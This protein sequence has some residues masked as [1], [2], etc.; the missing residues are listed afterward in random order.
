MLPQ[1]KKLKQS[2]RNL[3]KNMTNAER[4][5][6]P[7]IRRKQLKGVQFYRQKVIVNYIVDFYCH[8]AKLVIEVDGGQHF[9]KQGINT[10]LKRDTY[11]KELNLRVLRFSNY[12]VL[13]EI[14]CVVDKIYTY[15]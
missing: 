5:L 1:N 14:D 3:R 15:L 2:T 12:E 13:K 9:C 11:L 8:Q 10:D 7:K 4:K 6:W